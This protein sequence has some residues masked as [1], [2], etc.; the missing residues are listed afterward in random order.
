[1][2]A[3]SLDMSHPGGGGSHHSA[4]NGGSACASP[5][6][7]GHGP[8]L[9]LSASSPYG[10]QPHPGSGHAPP[11]LDMAAVKSWMAAGGARTHDQEF[12]GFK[13]WGPRPGVSMLSRSAKT[14]F[15]MCKHTMMFAVQLAGARCRPREAT[16]SLIT[17]AFWTP[18]SATWMTLTMMWA[19]WTQRS[20]K[21]S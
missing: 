8:P 21:C 3:M 15:L 9:Q 18:S 2:P 16:A 12:K 5:G 20:S 7:G 13:V 19:L 6:G 14:P 4:S 10:L 17:P 1:M 11:A